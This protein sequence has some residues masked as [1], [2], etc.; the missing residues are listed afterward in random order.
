MRENEKRID[1]DY[2]V[3]DKVLVQKDGILRKTESRWHI[4]P[5]TI[6]SVHTNGTIRV[7]HGNKSERLNI[8][9]VKPFY[10]NED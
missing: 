10:E 4:E 3:G 1:H 9:R 2:A 7:T 8:R 6:L 5:W